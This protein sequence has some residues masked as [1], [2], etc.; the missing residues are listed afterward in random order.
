MITSPSRE[1]HVWCPSCGA[2]LKQ[3]GDF[4]YC[5]RCNEYFKFNA[6]VK[7]SF[8]GGKTLSWYYQSQRIR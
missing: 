8:A 3:A 1:E 5:N 7:P 2:R 6:K 4:L